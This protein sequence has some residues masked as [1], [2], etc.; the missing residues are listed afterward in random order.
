MQPFDPNY[1]PK[2][3]IIPANPGLSCNGQTVVAW[4]VEDGL[5][6][7]AITV[8]GVAHGGHVFVDVSLAPRGA[9]E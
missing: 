2:T 9:D 6:A 7:R 5:V 8:P 3:T 4:V 1:K